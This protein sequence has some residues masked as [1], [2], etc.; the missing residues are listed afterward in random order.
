M[1]LA[2]MKDAINT[3]EWIVVNEGL[4]ASDHDNPLR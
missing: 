3:H 4:H 2:L 1:C